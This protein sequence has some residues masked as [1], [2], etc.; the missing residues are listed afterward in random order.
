MITVQDESGGGFGELAGLIAGAVREWIA[1]WITNPAIRARLMPDWRL[2]RPV[3]VTRQDYW[4]A[5]P[6]ELTG[7]QRR[8]EYCVDRMVHAIANHQFEQARFYSNEDLKAR[9]HLQRVRA[10]YGLA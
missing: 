7:A 8:V 1:K 4:G 6:A 10:K 2:L 9:E 3:G 5:A